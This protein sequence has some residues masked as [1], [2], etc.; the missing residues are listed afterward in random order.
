MTKC[1]S[2]A[3]LQRPLLAR[4]PMAS[5]LQQRTHPAHVGAVRLQAAAVQRYY[6]I[7]WEH[8]QRCTSQLPLIAHTPHLIGLC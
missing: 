7:G 3:L 5:R 2:A 6:V 1:L 4:Q 8:E